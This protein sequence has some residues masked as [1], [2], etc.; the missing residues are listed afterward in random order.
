MSQV[1]VIRPF[2]NFVLSTSLTLAPV[3]AAAAGIGSSGG[4]NFVEGELLDDY[5]MR[6]TEPLPAGMLAERAAPILGSLEKKVP[7]F[8]KDLKK[9]FSVLKWYSEPKPFAK[10]EKCLDATVIEAAAT[11]VACQT[12]FS[13]RIQSSLIESQNPTL[14]DLIVH[15]LLQR[16]KLSQKTTPTDEQLFIVSRVV[17]NEKSTADEIV[18]ALRENGF[19]NYLTVEQLKGT[20]AEA[21]T[22]YFDSIPAREKSAQ[23]NDTLL[24]FKDYLNK[25]ILLGHLRSEDLAEKNAHFGVT[26]DGKRFF[27]IEYTINGGKDRHCKSSFIAVFDQGKYFGYG[28]TEKVIDDLMNLGGQWDATKYYLDDG[29]LVLSY[30]PTGGT[31]PLPQC[32]RYMSSNEILN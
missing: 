15:E 21:V 7:Q 22:K 20:K 12:K 18:S 27:L 17:R 14:K 9:G 26:E 16:M 4:G 32:L 19:G 8:A 5:D 28:K 6:G 29:R 25:R 23:F 24:R 11:V 31:I 13:V 1:S 30:V 3:V 2:L 10:D